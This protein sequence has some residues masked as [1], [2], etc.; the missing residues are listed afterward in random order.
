MIRNYL[1]TD[2]FEMKISRDNQNLRETLESIK[3]KAALRIKE[4]QDLNS[5]LFQAMEI[6]CKNV[7]L[8]KNELDLALNRLRNKEAHQIGGLVL[9]DD[10]LPTFLDVLEN[11]L[12]ETESK[13]VKKGLQKLL[14]KLDGIEKKYKFSKSQIL[15]EKVFILLD[16][17]SR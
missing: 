7:V 10:Q 2:H 15:F 1:R 14:S 8:V 12:A 3:T 4:F 16:Q 6:V 17:N 5:A 11:K 13:N 9:K